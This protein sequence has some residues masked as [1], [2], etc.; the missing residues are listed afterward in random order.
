MTLT[1]RLRHWLP[2]AVG[3][4][5]LGALVAA[6]FAWR[7]PQM[8]PLVAFL[9]SLTLTWP[10]LTVG[11]QLLWFDRVRTDADVEAHAHDI[12]RAWYQEAAA[13]A[14]AALMGGL[15][16]CEYFGGALRLSWLSPVGITHVLVL[17]GV[18]F[19]GSYAWLRRTHR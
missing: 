1:G 2:A 13:T 9:V 15:V 8:A 6:L 3:G 17:G 4:A 10:V 18:T 16:F 14:F 11:L 12:E 19:L 7:N 5:V